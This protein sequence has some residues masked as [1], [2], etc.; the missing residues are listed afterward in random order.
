MKFQ[1]TPNRF[2]QKRIRKNGKN[3]V[4]MWF[5]FDENGFAEIDETQLTRTDLQKLKNKFKV[6]EKKYSEM[7]YADIQKAYS[8]KFNMSAVGKKKKDM[9]KELEG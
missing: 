6:V 8:L 7:N 4:I 2:V 3:K 9:I 5:K 1:S